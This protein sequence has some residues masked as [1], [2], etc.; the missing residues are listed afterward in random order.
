[1]YYVVLAK[2]IVDVPDLGISLVRGAQYVEISRATRKRCYFL[3]GGEVTD[4]TA[5]N[6]IGKTRQNSWELAWHLFDN[7]CY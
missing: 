2:C 3:I 6:V 4:I 7:P 5:T 1:M